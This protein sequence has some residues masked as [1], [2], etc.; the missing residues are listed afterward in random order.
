MSLVL[1]SSLG[2]Q[3]LASTVACCAA[4]GPHS[5]PVEKRMEEVK[6]EALQHGK[7]SDSWGTQC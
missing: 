3:E 4:K 2:T 1:S 7:R 6:G 5:A